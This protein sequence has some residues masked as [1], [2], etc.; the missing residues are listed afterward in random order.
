MLIVCM[1]D[2]KLMIDGLSFIKSTKRGVVPYAKKMLI[3]HIFL[4]NSDICLGS[5]LRRVSSGF[6]V[7]FR[8][9]CGFSL[10]YDLRVIHMITERCI[11]IHTERLIFKLISNGNSIFLI[12]PFF[13]LWSMMTKNQVNTSCPE[14]QQKLVL[15]YNLYVGQQMTCQ[16]CHKDLVVTWLFPLCLDATEAKDQNSVDPDL[17][18]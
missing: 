2:K 16:N 18:F 6:Y 1:C 10:L 7:I 8:A 5:L 13:I 11:R 14:C 4:R 15:D 9:A 12:Q 3:P 17:G